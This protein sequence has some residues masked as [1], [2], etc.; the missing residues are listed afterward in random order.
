MDSTLHS[1]NAS[2]DREILP[3]LM[4][5]WTARFQLSPARQKKCDNDR[6]SADSNVQDLGK[7]DLT[8]DD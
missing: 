6:I 2:K 3:I 1:Y 4:D 8:I 7:L 5:S